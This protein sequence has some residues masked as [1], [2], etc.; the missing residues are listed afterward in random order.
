MIGQAFSHNKVVGGGGRGVVANLHIC[1]S[2]S[3]ES[4]ELFRTIT[5][6]LEE[7]HTG[8]QSH[9]YICIYIYGSAGVSHYDGARP[10]TDH[11]YYHK[12]TTT[13]FTEKFIQLDDLASVIQSGLA[14]GNGVVGEGGRWI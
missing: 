11:Y 13:T 6:H 3:L 9:M 12:Q 1:R 7:T 4:V 14:N 5:R 8:S 2:A 10:E